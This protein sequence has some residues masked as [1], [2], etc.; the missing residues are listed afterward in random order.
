MGGLV[1]LITFMEAQTFWYMTSLIFNIKQLAE[2]LPMKL[3][4]GMLLQPNLQLE[5]N[6]KYG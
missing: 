1:L 6:S 4:L 5:A 3:I 2:K